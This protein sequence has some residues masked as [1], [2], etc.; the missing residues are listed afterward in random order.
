MFYV[1]T[2]LHD[3]N[4]GRFREVST[5]INPSGAEQ[6]CQA[7][8]ETFLV[9]TNTTAFKA[10]QLA[11]CQTAIRHAYC[12][13]DLESQVLWQTLLYKLSSNPN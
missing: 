5:K 10:M 8:N 3:S 2:Q 4:L 6:S 12:D 11:E 13:A 9:H 1:S 7:Y